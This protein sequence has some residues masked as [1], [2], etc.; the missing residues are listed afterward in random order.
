[1]SQP[2]THFNHGGK[3]IVFRRLEPSEREE[4]IEL[5][6]TC[7]P[8]IGNNAAY[9][10]WWLFDSRF[11]NRN[12]VLTCVGRLIAAYSFLP[13]NLKFADSVRS[14]A[15]VSNVMVHP[16]FRGQGL[17]IDINRLSLNCESDLYQTSIIIGRTDLLAGYLKVGYTNPTRLLY[18]SKTPSAG[19]A[20]DHNLEPVRA[21]D[22]TFDQLLDLFYHRIT[23]GVLKNLEFLNFRIFHKPGVSYGVYASLTSDRNV[24]GYIVFKRF[25]EVEHA[26]YKCHIIDL[27]ALDYSVFS[28]LIECA[29][30]HNADC[31][32]LNI[33]QPEASIFEAFL[34]RKGFHR[35]SHYNQDEHLIVFNRARSDSSFPTEGRHYVIS[36]D[37]SW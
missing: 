25:H 3:E 23:F 10:T 24:N 19:A 26:A 16:E 37:E 18:Y 33:L 8:R 20:L 29:E 27:V 22:R 30:Y 12:Y 28:S 15:I 34:L 14:G 1:M 32:E 9:A 6:Q 2:R 11:E 4:Y 21:F 36:D 5:H 17:F 7:F 35:G 13:I 31:S